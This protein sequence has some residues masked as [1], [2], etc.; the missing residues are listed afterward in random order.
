MLGE[1]EFYQ[2]IGNTA[3][4]TFD[5]FALGDRRGDYGEDALTIGDTI[6]IIM[7]AHA[8]IMADEEIENV[9][10]DLSCNGGGAFDAAVYVVAWMLGSCELSIYNSITESRATTNYTIDVN[11]DG[12]FDEN[13]SIADKNIY[14][15]ISPVSFSCGNLVPALLQAS[16]NATII[17]KTSSG[18]GCAVSQG[19]TA[20][21]TIFCISSAYQISTVK[22]GTYYSVDKGINPDIVLTKDESFYDREGLTEFING[23]K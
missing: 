13:D 4:V 6:T 12:I 7:L 11:M 23:L 19:V 18:G 16:G 5:S 22:N 17:G 20:D 2:K 10:L 3:Y 9:V 14:C 15:L 21:G 8:Q 1:V